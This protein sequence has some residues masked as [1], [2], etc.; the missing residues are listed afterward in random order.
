MRALLIAVLLSVA[1]PAQAA[2]SSAIN[3]VEWD[4]AVFEQARKER[5]LVILDLEAVWCHWCHVMDG[6]TYTDARVVDLINRH[7][8]A[9]KVDQDSR[10]DISNRYEDY[11]WPATIL[12]DPKGKEIAKL[13]GFIR[14]NRMV[15]LLQAFV[16]DP[17]PGPSI[18]EPSKIAWATTTQLTPAERADLHSR[19][20][21][22]YDA[23]WG[24]WG[25]HHKFLQWDGIEYLFTQVVEGDT[26]SAARARQTLDAQLTLI[27]G[28]WGGAYQYSDSG[29]WTNPH[30]EKIMSFQAGNIRAYALGY[31]AFGDKRYLDAA[32]SIER[33]LSDFLTSPEGAFY[34]SQDADLKQGEHSEGYFGLGDKAR[35]ALGIP[36]IDK[37]IYSR[38]NGWAIEALA[39]LYDAT[40]DQATLRRAVRAADYIIA[41]RNLGTGGFAHGEYDKAGP[42]LSDSLAMGRAFLA[43]YRSTGDKTW[44]VQAQNTGK[45]IQRYFVDE[46]AGARP[47]VRTAA[48]ERKDSSPNGDAV[49]IRTE[50]V[51]AARFAN[52]LVSLTGNARFK[53][54]R[55]TAMRYLTTPIIRDEF[56]VHRV[57][58]ANAEVA[59]APITIARVRAWAQRTAR[60]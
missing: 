47:G 38:E 4:S 43:L 37:N 11:G 44:L 54:M 7:F 60:R 31:A 2:D 59:G 41:K 32:R 33:Y 50:N 23:K 57:L 9:I 42:F 26:E 30:F 15:S 17:R 8:I 53:T 19:Q 1:A 24:S 52:D 39:V 3:W 22:Q 18:T 20:R 36:R 16:E 6:T 34:T 58:L 46:R 27:D 28:V 35:R 14:P 29:V 21:A 49:V 45:F 10:P 48:V 5:K 55:D 40:R 25:R 12:F 13:S 56:P 51:V